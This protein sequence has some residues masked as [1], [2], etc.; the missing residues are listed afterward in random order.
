MYLCKMRCIYRSISTG[1]HE[2]VKIRFCKSRLDLLNF[3]LMDAF[4]RPLLE[5][6]KFSLYMYV[7][8][9]A[10]IS[11]YCFYFTTFQLIKN[12]YMILLYSWMDFFKKKKK[13]N[14]KPWIQR[15]SFSPPSPFTLFKKQFPRNRRYEIIILRETNGMWR[16]CE[17]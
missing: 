9:C 6:K 1:W 3:L 15:L 5:W 13:R 17:L 11:F 12:P 7:C 10:Y 2:R 14:V 8:V 16:C 4:S